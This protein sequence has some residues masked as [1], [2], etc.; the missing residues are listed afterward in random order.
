MFPDNSLG[1]VENFL[2]VNFGF[3]SEKYEVD[4]LALKA[5]DQLFILHAD[6][7]QNCSTSTVRLV[8]SSQANMYQSISAGIHALAGPLHGGANSAVL[9]MLEKIQASDDGPRSSWSG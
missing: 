6:H 9:E 8:G 3:P 7:E 4:P 1:L 5:L 2:R